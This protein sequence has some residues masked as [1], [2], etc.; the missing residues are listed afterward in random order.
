MEF[1]IIEIEEL[2]SDIAHSYSVIVDDG[3]IRF[4][5]ETIFEI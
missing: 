2:S 3:V 1:E 4:N 5:N